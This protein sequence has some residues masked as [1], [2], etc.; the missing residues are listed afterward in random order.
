MEQTK[1]QLKKVFEKDGLVDE[2]ILCSCDML[3]GSGNKRLYIDV[4][5]NDYISS[6][7]YKVYIR[8][9]DTGMIEYT[10]FVSLEDAINFY[11]NPIS[12]N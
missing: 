3:D 5:C 2:Q 1:E 10:N 6:I 4:R 12:Q 8:K 9:F 7:T 11:V